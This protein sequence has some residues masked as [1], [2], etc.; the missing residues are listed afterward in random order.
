VIAG[1]G[2]AT[3]F[4]LRDL[5]ACGS[6]DANDERDAAG[7]VAQRQPV[8]MTRVA[9]AVALFIGGYIIVH[10]RPARNDSAP[11]GRRWATISR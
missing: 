8:W 1:L 6:G 2:L 9:G 3:M 4:D 7:E 11:S 10:D 5:A